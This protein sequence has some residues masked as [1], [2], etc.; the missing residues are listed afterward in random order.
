MKTITAECRLCEG[1]G[2]RLIWRGER[3]VPEKCIDCDGK[4]IREYTQAQIDAA[5]DFE[6]K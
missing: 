3:L 6:R 4:G 5:L 1:K 2:T